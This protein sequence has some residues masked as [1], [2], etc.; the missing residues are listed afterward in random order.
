[1]KRI[2]EIGTHSSG[3]SRLEVADLPKLDETVNEDKATFASHAT[4]LK[5]GQVR[6]N[7]NGEQAPAAVIGRQ[8]EWWN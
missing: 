8:S 6:P 4:E 1:M 7:G 5:P 2:I 3:D